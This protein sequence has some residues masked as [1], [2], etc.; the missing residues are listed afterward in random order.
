MLGTS[1]ERES[2]GSKKET[3]SARIL[4]IQVDRHTGYMVDIDG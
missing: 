4:V 1:K 3:K 2:S